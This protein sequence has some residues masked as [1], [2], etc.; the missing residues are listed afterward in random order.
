M[1][2]PLPTEYRI[3]I[4]LVK[5]VYNSCALNI[6]ESLQRV[7]LIHEQIVA[8]AANEELKS[9]HDETED[10][11]AIS[12]EAADKTQVF[13]LKHVYIVLV[14]VDEDEV[15]LGHHSEGILSTD[16]KFGLLRDPSTV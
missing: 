6:L 13:L 9:L 4:Q 12:L 2:I 8:C 10:G 1:P 14:A 11:I 3:V 16:G 5:A 7:H 15:L